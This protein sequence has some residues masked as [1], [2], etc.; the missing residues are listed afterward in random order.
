MASIRPLESDVTASGRRLI[1][2]LV[3]GFGPTDR[4]DGVGDDDVVEDDGAVEKVF[5]AVTADVGEAVV[6]AELLRRAEVAEVADVAALGAIAAN[7]PTQ[8]IPAVITASTSGRRRRSF[9]QAMEV[10]G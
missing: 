3:F 8:P 7:D 1:G 2:G 4:E 9:R 5:V 10:P 6:V